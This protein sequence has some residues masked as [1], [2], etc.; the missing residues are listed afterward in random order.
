MFAE[1]EG[2]AELPSEMT[3]WQAQEA[4]GECTD[5]QTPDPLRQAAITG[6]W[7]QEQWVIVAG[8]DPSRPMNSTRPC[9]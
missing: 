5:P 3:Y 8:G 9:R 2:P 7:S 1:D 6:E 4:T